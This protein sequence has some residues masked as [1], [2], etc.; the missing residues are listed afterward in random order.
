MKFRNLI[1]WSLGLFEA[2]F[3]LQLDSALIC[4]SGTYL[5]N[6]LCI[7]CPGLT[8]T[9]GGNSLPI[10][11]CI[12]PNKINGPTD[13]I[14]SFSFDNV[15][16]MNYWTATN[17]GRQPLTWVSDR[18]LQDGK[19]ISL[20]GDNGW[21]LSSSL[22][23]NLPSSSSISISIW[24]Q[25]AA[26][27]SV[28][29]LI[30]SMGACYD[31]KQF[32]I[33]ATTDWILYVGYQGSATNTGVYIKDNK[34][35]HVVF[36]QDFGI[37]KIF[38]DG[39]L[40]NDNLNIWPIPTDFFAISS[41]CS[42]Y[43]ACACEFT[44]L[45]DDVRIYNRG[46][47]NEEVLEMYSFIPPSFSPT[48]SASSIASY[49]A[50]V[51][52]TSSST[53]SSTT[54]ATASSTTSASSTNSPRSCIAGACQINVISASYG[55]S[56]G[57]SYLN[58]FLVISKYVCNEQ[59]MGGADYCTL[60]VYNCNNRA[61]GSS[62]WCGTSDETNTNKC[63]EAVDIAPY[64][65]KDF[66]I[67][68]SCGKSDTILTAPYTYGEAT[69][70][71]PVQ[72]R[73]PIISPSSSGSGTI[74]STGSV[75][76]TST[77]SSSNS[78]SSTA[79]S[80]VSVS[81][82]ITVTSTVSVS[83]TG[84][85]MTTV[86]STGSSTNTISAVSTVSSTM[87]PSSSGTSTNL[88]TSTTISTSSSLLSY[89]SSNSGT[90]SSTYTAF[91]TSASP[92]FSTSL[93]SSPSP[94]AN[95]TI[96]INMTF[97]DINGNLLTSNSIVEL[98][99]NAVVY[100]IPNIYFEVGILRIVD[101]VSQKILY[102]A[103]TET[104]VRRLAI[105][106]VEIE[107]EIGLDSYQDA[108]SFITIIQNN[109]AEFSSSILRFLS[110]SNKNIFGLATISGFTMFAKNVGVLNNT[111]GQAFTSTTII[112]PS[113]ISS[114][115]S[116]FSTSSSNEVPWE[117]IA[118]ATAFVSFI[119]LVILVTYCVY[120]WIQRRNMTKRVLQSETVYNPAG[121]I[122]PTIQEGFDYANPM[123]ESFRPNRLLKDSGNQ[124][125]SIR[126]HRSHIPG[127]NKQQYSALP[128]PY[129]AMSRTKCLSVN[130]DVNQLPQH[131]I[132]R[133]ASV[134]AHRSHI[135]GLD[136]PSSISTRSLSQ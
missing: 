15:E 8:S 62:S 72:L 77:S 136:V 127:L 38:V 94:S 124:H 126:A 43:L 1:L 80:T 7:N 92:S 117:T 135:P 108:E 22:L 98:I 31:G 87:S 83:S 120:T 81:S 76:S 11:A 14:L 128:I 26:S 113:S 61:C 63:M 119:L 122:Y 130:K 37:R 82:K 19:A 88:I 102:S 107:F 44:G 69:W 60:G 46:L 101:K 49:S 17:N 85:S 65:V 35:H 54:S 110:T 12:S 100:S 33:S 112:T 66:R 9:L 42:G 105:T 55:L 34:W 114:S 106:N 75:S 41:H 89:T 53:V 109:D 30:I 57:S 93:N 5:S 32:S 25:V 84:T 70:Q 90:S 116:L 45:I 27:S 95:A 99:S 79:S 10:E 48:A 4:P 24:F 125:A 68:Y 3:V 20:S 58:N 59:A 129:M 123:G 103:V 16:S 97:S 39:Q 78:L 118:I 131:S 51:T 36:I 52:T 74:T 115:S 73:C 40:T 91:S 47:S 56:C 64:C 50:S 96:G 111:L 29:G 133:H 18:F 104:K 13:S 28:P 132:N 21:F 2:L 67:T 6:N 23:S 134:R 121:G 86:S 71:E